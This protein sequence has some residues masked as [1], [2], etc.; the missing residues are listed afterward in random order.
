MKL[1][2]PARRPVEI[3]PFLRVARKYGKRLK[4]SKGQILFT[5]GDTADSIYYI[6]NGTV[7]L[8]VVSAQGKEAVFALLG[9]GD[10]FG[11]G[12]IAGQ[13]LRLI[14]AVALSSGSFI[15]IMKQEIVPLLHKDQTLAWALITYL[16]THQRKVQED[17][18]DQLFNST[19]KRLARAL[20]L[21]A[22][23]GTTGK[24][25]GTIPMVSQTLLA[26]I[27]GASRPRVSLL[28][29]KFRKLGFI[30]YD[31]GLTVHGSLLAV[32]LQD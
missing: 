9:P 13:S 20:L 28:M 15:R 27:I 3:E 26:E 18:I 12:C 22:N 10:F 8:S 16:I 29:N 1:A 19:E 5:M 25:E 31:H 7:R 14:T 17:L 6:Q 30:E 2:N 4:C 23:Y 11:E 32:V 21:L 24:T